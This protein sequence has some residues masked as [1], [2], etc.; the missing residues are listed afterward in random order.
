[1]RDRSAA[2][3]ITA[4]KEIMHGRT[5]PHF[6]F[7][8]VPTISIPRSCIRERFKQMTN[9]KWQM[10]NDKLHGGTNL[11]VTSFICHLSFVIC[12]WSLVIGH[13]LLVIGHSLPE[14]L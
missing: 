10:K 12:H 8:I 4:L 11:Q 13:L 7:L 6:G 14:D 3:H 2:K 5:M 1:M 9:D